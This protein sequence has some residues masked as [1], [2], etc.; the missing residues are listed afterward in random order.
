MCTKKTKKMKNNKNLG[1]CQYSGKLVSPENV[2]DKRNAIEYLKSLGYDI[3][4]F[5]SP[6]EWGN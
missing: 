5:E 2:L 6:L 1:K 4:K 3:L